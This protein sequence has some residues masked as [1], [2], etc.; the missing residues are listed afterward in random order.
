[1]IDSYSFYNCRSLKTMIFQG[2]APSLYSTSC[3]GTNDLHIYAHLSSSSD[4][5]S[6]KKSMDNSSYRVNWHDLDTFDNTLKL[7]AESTTLHVGENASITAFLNPLLADDIT[8]ESSD[9]NT[10]VVSNTGRIIAVAPGSAEISASAGDGKYTD[11]IA[12][13]VTGER[14][15]MPTS[16]TLELDQTILNYTSISTT[17]MQIPS[18][19]LHGIYF[20]QGGSLF[21]YSLVTQTYEQVYNFF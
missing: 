17:T 9:P 10:V 11:S 13:T 2:N 19:K 5:D 16:G 18:E 15:T 3:L 1:M 12:V 6:L 20:L 8:W 4:W 14:F 7:T 21:F